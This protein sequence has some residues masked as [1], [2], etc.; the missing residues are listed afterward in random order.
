MH[1]IVQITEK[2]PS[3]E[4]FHIAEELLFLLDNRK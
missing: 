4:F 1:L 3:S 2:T